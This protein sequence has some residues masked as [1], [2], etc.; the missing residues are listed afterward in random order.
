MAKEIKN[1]GVSTEYLDQIRAKLTQMGLAK[2]LQDKVVR[3]QYGLIY[4][5]EKENIPIEK[6]AKELMRGSL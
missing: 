1:G 2:D 4:A 3:N 6:V 5:A